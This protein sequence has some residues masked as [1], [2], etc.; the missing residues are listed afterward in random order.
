M[1]VV[2]YM[3]L[4]KPP[5]TSAVAAFRCFEPKYL[6]GLLHHVCSGPGEDDTHGKGVQLTPIM[7]S[8]DVPPP[9]FDFLAHAKY[10][11]GEKLIGSQLSPSKQSGF[12]TISRTVGKPAVG[13]DSSIE[14]CQTPQRCMR[15]GS[16]Q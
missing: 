16:A 10:S 15:S 11:I 8:H 5:L 1:Y 4:S 14:Y 2:T 3:W 13:K 9:K 12:S 6:Q 7:F